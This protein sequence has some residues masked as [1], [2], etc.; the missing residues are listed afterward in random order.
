MRLL[1]CVDGSEQSMK[2]VVKAIEIA[3]GCQVSD[4]AIIGVY[5]NSYHSSLYE[6]NDK[7]IIMGEINK[8][9][10]LNEKR[11]QYYEKYVNHAAIRFREKGIEPEIIVK[12][13]HPSETIIEEASKGNYDMIVMGNRGHGNK[14]RVLPGS[15]SSAVT[16]QTESSVVIVK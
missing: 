5:E 15:V 7:D 9:K 6:E 16:Q 4:V 3:S 1:V 13:G 8:I 11:K 10:S 2:A 14:F 12:E